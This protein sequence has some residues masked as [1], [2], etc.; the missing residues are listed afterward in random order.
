MTEL[1][2]VITKDQ[3]DHSVH[4]LAERI[5]KDYQDCDLVLI[6]VLKGA[7]IFLAD[8]ARNLSIPVQI[9]FIA[10]SSYGDKTE[11]SGSVKI[12]KKPGIDL[13]NKYVLL[14]EDIIDT[15]LTVEHLSEYLQSL[16]A[17]SVK[18]CAFIDKRERRAREVRI[19]YLCHAISE[20]FLVGYGLDYADNY[21]Q[22]KEVYNLKL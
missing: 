11:T 18:V 16:G 19:D 8:L 7:F 20:G 12:S 3:I 5:S 21:R 1:I 6:G 17:R 15:G 9:D 13:V 14:V 10:A 4:Q 22:L 2:P